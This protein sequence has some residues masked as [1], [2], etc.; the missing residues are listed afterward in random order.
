MTRAGSSNISDYALFSCLSG[1]QLDLNAEDDAVALVLAECLARPYSELIKSGIPGP[2]S[3]KPARPAALKPSPPSSMR[4]SPIGP[5]IATPIRGELLAQLETLSRKPR[6][7]KRKNSGFAEKDRSA[8]AKVPRLRASSSSPSTPVQK[9]E[10]A[11]SP[12]AEAPIVLSSQL[13]SKFAAKAKNLL[14]GSAEQPLA[15][16]PI[17]V[18]NPPTESVRSPPRRVE[19]LKKKAPESQVGEDGDTLLLNAELATRAV[20][21]ILKDSDLG[22]SKALPV[23]EAL[24]LSLQRVAS[25]SPVSCWVYF[26]VYPVLDVDF[27]FDVQVATHLK[28]LAEKA[29]LNEKHVKIAR[30]YKAKWLL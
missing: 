9:P 23:D 25:V 3:L 21:S 12:A 26:H 17:T 10:Q 28:G 24:A 22:R 1:A 27:M 30:V 15:V 11:P 5:S 14:G 4:V 7:V 19:N 2:S 13:P 29:K 6:S 18:L 8:L 20:S 16:V